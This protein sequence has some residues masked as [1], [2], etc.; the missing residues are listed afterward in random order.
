MTDFVCFFDDEDLPTVVDWR[1]QALSPDFNPRA[2]EQTDFGQSTRSVALKS[3]TL[4]G[5]CAQGRQ[6]S[7]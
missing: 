3:A 5:Q 2:N 1:A 4:V 7:M 6:T